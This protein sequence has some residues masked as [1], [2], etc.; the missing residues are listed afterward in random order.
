MIMRQKP[1]VQIGV[2]VAL[3]PVKNGPSM[4]KLVMQNMKGA[5]ILALRILHMLLDGVNVKKYGSNIRNMIHAEDGKHYGKKAQ[6]I[7]NKRA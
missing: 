6:N 2:P 4:W 5:N 1:T 3:V 7:R